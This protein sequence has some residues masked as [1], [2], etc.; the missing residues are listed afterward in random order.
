MPRPIPSA[1]KLVREALGEDSNLDVNSLHRRTYDLMINYR[2]RYYESKVDAFLS[3][4]SFLDLNNDIKR[5]LKEEMLRPIVVGDKTYSNFMEEASRRVSQSF[6]PISGKLAELSAQ[7]ELDRVGLQENVHYTVREGRTDLTV[8]HPNVS[9]GRVNH[10]IEVKN[11]KLRERGARGLVFDAESLF[12]FFDDPG[13]F[14][15][16]NVEVLDDFCQKTNG[17]CYIPPSTLAE[18][19]YSG[20]RFR[21]NTQFG[22][23]MLAFVQNGRIP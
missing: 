18:M 20:S 15:R 22:R 19:E 9:S 10:R 1:R 16:N 6:Q 8:Y 13:E 12:G 23:D 5:R 14:T 2:S 11:V 4:L 17:Y 3:R 21:P 7:R